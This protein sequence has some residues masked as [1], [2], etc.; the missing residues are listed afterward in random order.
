MIEALPHGTHPPPKKV[1]KR[2]SF[3]SKIASS[4][5]HRWN[6][7]LDSRLKNNFIRL[8]HTWWHLQLTTKSGVKNSSPSFSK[9]DQG[10]FNPIPSMYGIF[11]YIW[12]I[13]LANV[14][15]F[16][17]H[18]SYGNQLFLFR[19]GVFRF[20]R[21]FLLEKPRYHNPSWSCPS[22]DSSIAS[23]EFLGSQN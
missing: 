12:L 18:G 20:R 21:V 22:P 17:I 8:P 3:Q 23:S 5:K 14:G 4:P 16:T 2:R 10:W 1:A 11:T 15:I 6:H 9:F 7:H 13:F 19:F